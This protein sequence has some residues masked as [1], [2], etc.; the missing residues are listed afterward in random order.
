MV[1]ELLGADED[2]ELMAV[3]A[4]GHPAKRQDEGE[5]DPLEKKIFLRR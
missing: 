4:L 2:L 3:V 1:D 5:R